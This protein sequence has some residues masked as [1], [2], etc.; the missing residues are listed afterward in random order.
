MP[1][2]TARLRW[3]TAVVALA[4][5]SIGADRR[6]TA[7]AAPA[8]AA[9]AGEVL[10]QYCVTCHNARLKTAGL[11]IDGLDASRVADQAPQWEKIVAKLRTGEMPPPGR[12]RPDAATSRAIA[13][14][15]EKELDAA[16]LANPQPGRVPV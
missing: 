10:T 15:L 6:V 5:V 7:R 11:Q 2:R 3:L 1:Q 12:P 9:A 4:G 8:P 13:A 16:A 14:S